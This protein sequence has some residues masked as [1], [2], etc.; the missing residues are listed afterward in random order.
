MNIDLSG[1]S[2]VDIMVRKSGTENCYR[3]YLQC[4]DINR[5]EECINYI[6]EKMRT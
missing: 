2:D 5:I 3:V 1:F 4:D 6:E